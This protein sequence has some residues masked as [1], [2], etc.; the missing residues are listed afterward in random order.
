MTPE[1]SAS[2]PVEI[3]RALFE[4]VAFGTRRIIENFVEHGVP[5]AEVVACGGIA[6]RSELMMQLLA[7]VTGLALTIPDSSQIPARG[8]ALFGGLAA[9]SAR[10][11]FDDIET[12]VARLKPDI[13]RRYEPSQSHMVTYRD[14]YS[15]F[16]ALHDE[17]G[18]EHVEWLHR[19]KQIRRTVMASDS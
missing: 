10:G 17:F 15:V 12:A 18:R 8:A 1:R 7:D 2:P 16:C 4:S 14:L 9:G 6:E 3:Y 13:A 19:L 11:G 5:I